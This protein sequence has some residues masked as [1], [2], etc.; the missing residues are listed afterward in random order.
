M[1]RSVVDSQGVET[2]K[3]WRKLTRSALLEVVAP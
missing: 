1:N 2:E 3:A